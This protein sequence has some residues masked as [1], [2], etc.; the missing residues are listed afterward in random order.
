[1]E[2]KGTKGRTVVIGG[3][4]FTIE[5]FND[6]ANELQTFPTIATVN[7]TFVSNETAEANAYLIADAFNVRQSIDCS[8]TELKQRHDEAMELLRGVTNS[9]DNY[10]LCI[11]IEQL[12][13]KSK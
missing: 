4:Y 10:M 12:L 6:N 3:K 1:M 2:F 9:E 13:N 11:E 5:A 7:T 8:L